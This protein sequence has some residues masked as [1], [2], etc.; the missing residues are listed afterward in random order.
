MTSPYSEDLR[1]IIVSSLEAGMPNAQAALTFSVS[2]SL[3]KRYVQR[4][5]RGGSLAPKKRLG[6][7]TKL[8]EELK[9]RPFAERSFATPR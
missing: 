9:E 6:A 7:A 5:E 1:R 2:L 3:V 4:A 8:E